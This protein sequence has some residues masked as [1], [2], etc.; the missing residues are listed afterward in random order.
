[1]KSTT[2]VNQR[3]LATLPRGVGL[4]FSS[5]LIRQDA[6][7]LQFRRGL[8]AQPPSLALKTRRPRPRAIVPVQASH[9][10]IP[11]AQGLFNP[12]ND[13]D[14]CGVGFIA[15]LSKNPTRRTVTE[16]LEM[17]VR[18]TH[19]GACG[20]EA[21]T[22]DGA[23][24]LVGIPHDFLRKEI[25]DSG[26]FSLPK[27]GDYGLGMAFLP[28]NNE[29]YELAKS[30]LRRVVESRGHQLLGWRSV[31]TDSSDLGQGA[32]QTQPIIEQFFITK[33]TRSND[34]EKT[35]EQQ[36]FCLRKLIEQGWRVAGMT[37]DDAY[38][39]SLSSETVVYKGQL[40]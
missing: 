24:I 37:D 23:G 27:A 12:G 6:G 2:S 4:A 31:P 28:K 22:G 8:R 32:L 25:E 14:A 40:T 19:R 39:C 9:S 5:S 17:L 29:Q 30:A 18:M 3:A 36:M 16:S 7:S 11:P 13:K 1:M 34:L 10:A 21:N 33:S 38:I 26:T 15:E 20:C 35:M